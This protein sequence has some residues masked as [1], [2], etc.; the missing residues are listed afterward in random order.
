MLAV[1]MIS[2]VGVIFYSATTSVV[3]YLYVKSSTQLNI[4]KVLKKDSFIFKS[5]FIVECLNLIN[6][7]SAYFQSTDS[8]YGGRSPAVLYQACLDPAKEHTFELNK[9]YPL[10]HLLL[11]S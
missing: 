11:V 3:R 5:I 8:E 2:S 7:G 9:L 4:Q 10:N 1:I 6:I